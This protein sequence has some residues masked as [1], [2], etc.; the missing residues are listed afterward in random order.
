MTQFGSANSITN[1]MLSN[2]SINP[3]I[4]PM[5]SV[6][7][8]PPAVSAPP[9]P[10]S[11]MAALSGIPN[12]NTGAYST[13]LASGGFQLADG[14]IRMPDGSTMMPDG[15]TFGG[16]PGSPAA[17]PLTST[18][19]NNALGAELGVSLPTIMSMPGGDTA[20]VQQMLGSLAGFAPGGQPASSG[21][22]TTTYSG[23]TYTSSLPETGPLLPN[24]TPGGTVT[25]APPAVGA[26]TPMTTWPGT[27]Q[28][29]PNPASAPPTPPL[30][31]PF[32]PGTTVPMTQPNPT[33]PASQ[34]GTPTSTWPGGT[35]TPQTPN[36][37]STPTTGTGPGQVPP[38]TTTTPPVTSGGIEFPPFEQP[39]LPQLPSGPP[40]GDPAR[41]TPSAPTVLV[42]RSLPTPPGI[43]MVQPHGDAASFNAKYPNAHPVIPAG[44]PIPRLWRG[45]PEQT[46]GGVTGVTGVGTG[47]TPAGTT[48]G[49]P[50]APG[51]THAGQTDA[52]LSA[53][54]LDQA[55]AARASVGMDPL[56]PGTPVFFNG[57]YDAFAAE[58]AARTGGGG[59]SGQGGLD[60]LAARQAQA[61]PATPATSPAQSSGGGWQPPPGSVPGAGQ[62][63]GM[64][65]LPDGSIADANGNIV[66]RR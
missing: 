33:V 51:G 32:W 24:G 17:Q 53:Q 49:P 36:T 66:F 43:G 10:Q 64:W 26:P 58:R 59:V 9:I 41:P 18:Q 14:S 19:L 20:T 11:N 61:T 22:P 46:V 31:G 13:A 55:N 40:S 63:A 52:Q 4:V 23:G 6:T 44:V 2:P 34:Q 60:I 30:E 29:V 62:Y 21:A 38:T 12:V 65:R 48:P 57:V 39:H 8:A 42:K 45:R 28:G 25:T 15:S 37:P 27:T 47:L 50:V 56:P 7:S 5:T 54:F 1:Q 16:G 35:E 3:G